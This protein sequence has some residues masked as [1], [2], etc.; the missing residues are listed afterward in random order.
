MQ[1][2]SSSALLALLAFSCIAHTSAQLLPATAAAA[3]APAPSVADTTNVTEAFE[4][5]NIT[6][7]DAFVSRIEA[8]VSAPVNPTGLVCVITLAGQGLT[9]PVN[10]ASLDPASQATGLLDAAITCTGDDSAIIEG[11]SALS[12]FIAN[13]TGNEVD[14]TSGSAASKLLW[15]SAE[16][17]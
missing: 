13:F 1:W 12:Q 14:L 16:M 10:A 8:G 15:Y 11:G 5:A 17:H 4:S 6:R 3:L 9:G 7:P 2:V